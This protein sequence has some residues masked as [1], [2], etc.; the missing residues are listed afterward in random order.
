DAWVVL[1]HLERLPGK[2]AGLAAGCLRLVGPAFND[3]PQVTVRRQ[4]KSRGV[5][6]IDHDR[7][8]EESLCLDYP[9]FR[10]WKERRKRAQVQ[11][12]SAEVNRRPRGGSGRAGSRNGGQNTPETP[13]ASM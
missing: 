8:I 12:V 13:P 11:I 4:G 9:L 7:L 6:P 1:R 10:Y 5:M 2:I 3:E